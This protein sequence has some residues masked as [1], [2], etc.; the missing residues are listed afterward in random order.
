M[1]SGF[2]VRA[3]AVMLAASLALTGG[4]GGGLAI[5]IGSSPAHAQSSTISSTADEVK[6]WTR[7]KWNA[8]K[9][10]WKKDKAKWNACREKAGDKKLKGKASWGFL[11]DCMKAS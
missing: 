9:R 2:R 4:L 7:K 1:M 10:E 8:M 5:A 3:A 11:Y 6:D